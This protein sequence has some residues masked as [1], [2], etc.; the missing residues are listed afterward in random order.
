METTYYKTDDKLEVITPIVSTYTI[1][2]LKAL[3]KEYLLRK[4]MAEKKLEEAM[5]QLNEV[6]LLIAKYTELK[7][8]EKLPETENI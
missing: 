1:A 6:R 4:A 2:E 5:S 8:V 7:I 3:E